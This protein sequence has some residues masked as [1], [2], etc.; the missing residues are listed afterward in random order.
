MIEGI[1]MRQCGIKTCQNCVEHSDVRQ[2]ENATLTLLR[3]SSKY[4]H[5][6]AAYDD[7]HG[8][9]N[10][11]GGWLSREN[12]HPVDFLSGKPKS[13]PIFPYRLYYN[14]SKANRNVTFTHCED[15][16]MYMEKYRTLNTCEGVCRRVLDEYASL[17]TRLSFAVKVKLNRLVRELQNKEQEYNI[18]DGDHE[19]ESPVYEKKQVLHVNDSNI[20]G[21][22]VN[23]TPLRNTKATSA[24]PTGYIRQRTS[25]NSKPAVEA[26]HIA[27][28]DIQNVYDFSVCTTSSTETVKSSTG[29]TNNTIDREML[30]NSFL[31]IPFHSQ[32]RLN[33]RHICPLKSA[34]YQSSPEGYLHR[35]SRASVKC[36]PINPTLVRRVPFRRTVSLLGSNT[37][38]QGSQYCTEE[39]HIERSIGK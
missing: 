12:G 16:K 20:R 14:Q 27:T 21:V 28:L 22:T 37:I 39:Q 17:M 36:S 4:N 13:K 35:T 2:A 19:K 1:K 18:S 25:L 7:R 8:T 6:D 33:S 11:F 31:R 9:T 30:E 24:I 26:S 34:E 15:I 3:I 23:L 32:I 10:D 29:L 5:Y 38:I